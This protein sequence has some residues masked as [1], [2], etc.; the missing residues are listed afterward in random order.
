MSRS[1][2]KADR[3]EGRGQQ[4]RMRR[5]YVLLACTVIGFVG[6]AAVAVRTYRDRQSDTLRVRSQ[7]GVGSGAFPTSTATSP[8]VSVRALDH[9]TVLIDPGHN[10]ANVDHTMEIARLI[11]IGTQQRTCDTPGTRTDDG[12]TEAEYNLD[13]A[14]QVADMLRSHGATV[15]MTRET[16]DGW[17]PCI[18]E[19][20]GIGN[21]SG[22]EVAVSIHADGGPATG[23]GFHV[24]YPLAVPGL[25]DDIAADSYALALIMREEF[26]ARTGMPRADYIAQDGLAARSDLGGLNLSDVPKV[27]IESGNMRNADDAQLLHDAAFRVRVAEAIV[28]S[29]VM[30]LVSR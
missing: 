11:D 26:G 1:W 7:D 16:N 12:Y 29:I 21:R 22:A 28:A 27:F 6:G 3:P 20:A 23:R 15:A 18:D 19:R 13:I 5:A 17:G 25:T 9:R 10:G 4:R 30:Y 8:A 14:I 2:P 24:I